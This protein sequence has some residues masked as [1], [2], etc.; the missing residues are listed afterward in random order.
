MNYNTILTMF[1]FNP[2]DFKPDISDPVE[3]YGVFLLF[4]EQRTDINR[5]CPHCNSKAV[6]IKDYDTILLKNTINP[7]QKVQIFVKKVRFKCKKCKIS[8]T[9]ALTNVCANTNI[10]TSIKRLII[11][12]FRQMISFSDIAKRYDVSQKT[13]FNIFDETFPYVERSVLPKILCI[14]EFYFTKQIDQK[15]CCAL[16]DY[17][18]GQLVDII[19]NRRKEY[20]NEYFS[21]ISIKEREN[22]KYFISDMY[23]E[24]AIVRKKYFPNAIPIV[25]KFHIVIQL[26]TAI[27][28]IRTKVMNSQKQTNYVLYTF[29]KNNWELF[30]A[31]RNKIPNKNYK[32]KKTGYQYHYEDLFYQCLRLDNNLSRANDI[33]QEIICK[34]KFAPKNEIEKKIESIADR[35]IVSD[36]EELQKVGRTYLKWKIGIINAYSNLEIGKKLTNAIAETTNNHIK[37]IIKVSYGLSNFERFRKRALIISRKQ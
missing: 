10:P 6:S 35:L 20:L 24:Y 1:G 18:R 21:K 16:V 34:L 25:D 5:I 31:S 2:N 27:K 29:M 32:S 8:F 26:T 13:V 28:K 3:E 7:G 17:N 22:V 15:Y 36:N 37:T 4:L 23:D 19:K 11:N 30:E 12:E 14:D 9:P 33:L